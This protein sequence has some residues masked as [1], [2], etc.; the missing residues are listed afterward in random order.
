MRREF[1]R[2]GRPVSPLLV[3]PPPASQATPPTP[4]PA[5]YFFG[6]PPA[7]LSMLVATHDRGVG[8]MDSNGSSA[9]V[10]VQTEG[11]E[12]SME[13]D[14]NGPETEATAIGESLRADVESG[15]GSA[16]YDDD[17]D[18]EVATSETLFS[19]ER[20]PVGD[21]NEEAGVDASL[22]VIPGM[23]E[24]VSEGADLFER[25]PSG[26]V[27]GVASLVAGAERS[28][29]PVAL[30][31]QACL[32]RSPAQM[33]CMRAST[34]MGLSI[35]LECNMMWLVRARVIAD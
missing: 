8:S 12:W 30:A 23:E 17:F 14:E 29:S 5:S 16:E 31:L 21:G 24:L 7:M 11:I 2:P 22:R 20:E 34:S 35:S 28:G 3:S 33:A 13:Q 32:V 4:S 1:L 10:Q 26:E 19:S 27:E 18:P 6:S 15:D 25:L 9:L